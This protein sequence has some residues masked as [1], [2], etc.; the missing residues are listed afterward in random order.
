MTVYTAENA[1]TYNPV[2]TP[3]S[4]GELMVNTGYYAIPAAAV[5]NSV[6]KLC[7]LPANCI[8]VDAVLASPDLD[9]SGSPA[10][11]VDVGILDS[12]GTSLVDNS[13]IIDGSTVCQAGGIARMDSINCL[14]LGVSTSD[15]VV[16]LKIMTAAATGALGTVYLSI[17]YRE[18][19][20]GV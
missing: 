8:L 19:E 20:Y 15:R 9:S 18:A 14:A 2:A 11:V 3:H 5:V 1:Q 10:I 6:V 16:A 13:E 7:V 12:A 4:A 17:L